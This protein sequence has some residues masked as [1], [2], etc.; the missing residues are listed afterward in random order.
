[1]T[2]NPT[3]CFKQVSVLGLH[4]ADSAFTVIHRRREKGPGRP[5]RPS[6]L[7]SA[8]TV[9]CP[10]VSPPLSGTHLLGLLYGPPPLIAPSPLLRSGLL[11][12]ARTPSQ[13]G[14]QKGRKTIPGN[15]VSRRFRE[16]K[17]EGASN[18]LPVSCRDP[19]V[20]TYMSGSSYSP[21]SRLKIQS[22]LS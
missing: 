20:E 14:W 19:H 2:E 3:G 8:L 10:P 22:K 21:K 13:G 7:L 16:R 17:P 4:V 6:R 5:G 15:G 18:P 12:G 11:L 1:M 9:A